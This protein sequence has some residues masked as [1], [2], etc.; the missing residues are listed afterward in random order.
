MF[1]AHNYRSWSAEE[2][3]LLK[4]AVQ[5]HGAGNWILGIVCVCMCCVFYTCVCV[6]VE[7]GGCVCVNVGVYTPMHACITYTTYY[8]SG[9][10]DTRPY[11]TTVHASVAESS[12]A[13]H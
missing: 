8:H 12:Y 3:A 6:C 7:G 11:W 13:G 4:E 1:I 10:R 9:I 5:K 2:D